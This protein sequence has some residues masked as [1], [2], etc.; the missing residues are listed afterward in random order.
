GL[1]SGLLFPRG[2]VTPINIKPPSM[3]L[4]SLCVRAELRRVVIGHA[5]LAQMLSQHT[6]AVGKELPHER[7]RKPP[8]KPGLDG[9]RIS[10][11]AYGSVRENAAF[12]TPQSH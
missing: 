6:M 8:A 5:G 4:S 3:K 11:S 1:H 7:D 9:Q 2:K 12:V 10:N